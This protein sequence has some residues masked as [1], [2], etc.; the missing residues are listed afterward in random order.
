MMEHPVAVGAYLHDAGHLMVSSDIMTAVVLSASAIA[1]V[2]AGWLQARAAAPGA[3]PG[4]CLRAVPAVLGGSLHPSPSQRPQ[5]VAKD[6]RGSAALVP[7]GLRAACQGVGL[8]V[9]VPVAL[10]GVVYLALAGHLPRGPGLPVLATVAATTEAGLVH[11]SRQVKTIQQR[12]SWMAARG[13]TS[14]PPE[15]PVNSCSS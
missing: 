6:A 2:A 12:G 3:S 13:P 11:V 14:R 10:L 15:P 9:L 5:R 4:Q 1:W 7:A 8:T